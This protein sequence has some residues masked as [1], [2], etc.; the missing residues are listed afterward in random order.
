MPDGAWVWSALVAYRHP[1][2]FLLETIN[3][4]DFGPQAGEKPNRS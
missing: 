4:S 1:L 2:A 3:G